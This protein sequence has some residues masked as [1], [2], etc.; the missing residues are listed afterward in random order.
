M[1]KKIETINRKKLSQALMMYK[2]YITMYSEEW[3][4]DEKRKASKTLTVLWIFF[5]ETVKFDNKEG[6]GFEEEAES[7]NDFCDII[8]TEL[9]NFNE[10][11][12]EE[13]QE[14]EA[15]DIYS[16]TFNK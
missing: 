4:V 13:K 16:Y 12:K 8:I 14:K 11:L 1:I 3:S 9:T 2:N 7:V 5:S 10:Q 15:V 6:R